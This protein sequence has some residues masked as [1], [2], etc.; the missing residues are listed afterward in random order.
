[1]LSH[2]TSSTYVAGWNSSFGGSGANLSVIDAV[3]ALVPL[4]AGCAIDNGE[5]DDLEFAGQ[6]AD[7]QIVVLTPA[8]ILA[9]DSSWKEKKTI[10]RSYL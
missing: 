4:L 9:H 1:M 6:I 8:G 3:D 7:G 5:I 2:V 10:F